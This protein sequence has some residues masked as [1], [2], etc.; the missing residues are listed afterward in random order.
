MK[1]NL[2]YW[3]F[4]ILSGFIGLFPFIFVIDMYPG[5]K[6]ILFLSFVWFFLFVIIAAV[7]FPKIIRCPSCKEPLLPYYTMR[8]IKFPMYLVPFVP[9]ECKKCGCRI[10]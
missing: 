3:S 1:M 4:G 2:L 7:L 6:V 5:N 10:K 8:G 9:V